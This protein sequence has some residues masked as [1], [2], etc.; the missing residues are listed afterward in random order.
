MYKVEYKLYFKDKPTNIKSYLI[1]KLSNSALQIIINF[2]DKHY[3]IEI[4]PFCDIISENNVKNSLLCFLYSGVDDPLSGS[5]EIHLPV[6]LCDWRL[7]SNN[8]NYYKNK[9]QLNLIIYPE[10]DYEESEELY[11]EK[12]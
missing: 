4:H 10:D 11:Y 6:E 9:E 7:Y 5:F 12:F 3:G 2:S 1:K 8:F